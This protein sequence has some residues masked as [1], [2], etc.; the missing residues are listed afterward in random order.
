MDIFQ[1]NNRAVY[2]Y[3]L[4]STT[5]EDPEAIIPPIRICGLVFRIR[6]TTL[7]FREL[8]QLCTVIL[9]ALC[10]VSICMMYLRPPV[11][12]G[13]LDIRWLTIGAL[14]AVCSQHLFSYFNLLMAGWGSSTGRF[15][16]DVKIMIVRG[17]NTIRTLSR[18]VASPMLTV[19]LALLLGC[20]HTPA[21]LFLCLLSVLGELQLG[22]SEN[23]NQYDV[24]THEKFVSD[25]NRLL[26]ETVHNYQAAHPLTNVSQVSFVVYALINISVTTILLLFREKV[27]EAAIFAMP[28][29]VMLVLYIVC[30]PIFAHLSYLK[31][32]WTFCE[33][34]IYRSLGDVLLLTLVTCFIIV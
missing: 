33:Y 1:K 21:L 30:L 3:I 26:L 22:L 7:A 2:K 4:F 25:E 5:M 9:S 15:W 14:V 18:V 24:Q 19:Q 10:I 23:Q 8:S 27:E 11:F 17:F 34:E 31:G 12:Y 20:T 32:I 16:C 13:P 28:I 6:A 29:V